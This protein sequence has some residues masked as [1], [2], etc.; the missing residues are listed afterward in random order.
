VS[1]EERCTA[2]EKRWQL[3]G[4]LFSKTFPDQ[5][6][7]QG[8]NDTARLFREEKIRAVVDDARVADLLIPIDHPIGTE[9]ICTDDSYYQ[10]FNRDT[11]M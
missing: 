8:A 6:L 10:T 5:M 11:T 1:E 3:G 7:S 2:Y 4:V 9:W